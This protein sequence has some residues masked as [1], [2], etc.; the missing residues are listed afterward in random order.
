[1]N[2][3][4]FPYTHM[5]IQYNTYNTNLHQKVLISCT[6]LNLSADSVKIKKIQTF[7]FFLAQV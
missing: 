1:M 4:K 2:E 7:I 6:K 3:Y 5:Y